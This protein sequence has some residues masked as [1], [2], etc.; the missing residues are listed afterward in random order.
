MRRARDAPARDN[1]QARD[2]FERTS[3]P[4]AT[5]ARDADDADDV[6]DIEHQS[7]NERQIVTRRNASCSARVVMDPPP[8]G[9]TP[10]HIKHIHLVCKYI[11][12]EGA[13]F[14]RQAI[15]KHAT[16]DGFE[17]LL[18][19]CDSA[20][21]T[22]E[23]AREAR[24]GR[25]YYVICRDRALTAHA[26][27]NGRGA[28][29]GDCEMHRAGVAAPRA[30]CPAP[31]APAVPVNAA[32]ARENVCDTSPSVGAIDVR[33]AMEK[34]QEI[35]AKLAATAEK[36]AEGETEVVE[37]AGASDRCDDEHAGGDDDGEDLDFNALVEGF[38]REE[39]EAEEEEPEKAPPRGPTT[40]VVVEDAAPTTDVAPLN[41]DDAVV[42]VGK[43]E[44]AEAAAPEVEQPVEEAVAK[45]D[46][47]SMFP[48]TKPRPVGDLGGFEAVTRVKKKRKPRGPPKPKYEPT[49]KL[50]DD[51]VAIMPLPVIDDDYDAEEAFDDDM[52]EEVAMTD[53]DSPECTEVHEDVHALFPSSVP[54][55]LLLNEEEVDQEPVCD[56]V[57][58]AQPTEVDDGAETDEDDPEEVVQD[59]LPSSKPQPDVWADLDNMVVASWYSITEN[60]RE[61]EQN[62]VSLPCSTSAKRRKSDSSPKDHTATEPEQDAHFPGI[63]VK[64]SADDAL[65]SWPISDEYAPLP[66]F[67]FD[68]KALAEPSFGDP[69]GFVRDELPSSRPQ[70]V[71]SPHD[72]VDDAQVV[73]S[74]HDVLPGIPIS[75]HKA[76][77]KPK[78]ATKWTLLTERIDQLVRSVIDVA[79]VSSAR[80]ATI[81]KRA[82]EKVMAHVPEQVQQTTEQG[83][84]AFLTDARKERISKLCDDYVHATRGRPKANQTL[85]KL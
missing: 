70:V 32:H 10:T 23:R 81:R 67:G 53:V 77:A 59:A 85:F 16:Q 3:I 46:L 39:E 31:P 79:N 52:D 49:P 8:A 28:G 82:V 54:R 75:K 65:P 22:G 36:T 21:M 72:T 4:G 66:I 41:A 50:T 45:I 15:A 6:D 38:V 18:N 11:E 2:A 64:V 34:A 12:L 7:Q 40:A 35:A 27:A 58:D 43:R 62:I 73:D 13:A 76:Q 30:A 33:E 60:A 26:H 1:A 51:L 29:R 19:D 63:T 74:P 24:V 61:I 25:E 37:T 71:D 17:F 69:E 47:T 20:T 84:R 5:R 14:E 68:H 57:D 48:S 44:A 56:A 9:V 42:D 80:R 78:V 83:V 55:T